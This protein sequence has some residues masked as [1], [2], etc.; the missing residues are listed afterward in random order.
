VGLNALTPWLPS[1]PALAG[2]RLVV[3]DYDRDGR[4]DVIAVVNDGNVKV[5][6]LRAKTDGTAFVAPQLLWSGSLPFAELHP[7]ALNVNPDGMADLAFVM[8]QGGETRVQWL[9]AN[10]R[11]SSPATMTLMTPFDSTLDWN[12][13]NRPF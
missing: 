12:A 4:D 5:Y 9:R 1:A 3:G 13:S 11:T 10:E 7:L 2:A 6:G 8:N